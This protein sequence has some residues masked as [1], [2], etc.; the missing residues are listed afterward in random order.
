MVEVEVS[1]RYEEVKTI[2]LN[3]SLEERVSDDTTK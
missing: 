3:D 2:R 1:D